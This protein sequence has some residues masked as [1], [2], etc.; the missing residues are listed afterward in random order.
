MKPLLT[1]SNH[2][3]IYIYFLLLLAFGV[4]TGKFLMS[5]AIIALTI[6]W[7]FEAGFQ[8]KQKQ[9]KHLKYAPIILSG[10]FI[11]QVFWL[12]KTEVLLDGL[13]D[14][15]VKLPLVFLPL[16]I[17]TSPHLSFLELKKVSFSFLLGLFI[18]SLIIFC[19]HIGIIETVKGSGT[20]RD[21]SIFMS[22]IRYSSLVAFGIIFLLYLTQTTKYKIH[23]IV[24]ILWFLFVLYILQS[25]SG[26]ISIL[27]S[28]F[29]LVIYKIYKEGLR[30]N[31]KTILTLIIPILALITYS[32]VIFVDY[33]KIK[34]QHSLSNLSLQSSLGEKYIH[35]KSRLET[36]NGH[37]LWINIAPIETEKAWNERSDK[38]FL[39]TKP[40]LYRYLTSKGYKKDREGVMALTTKDIKN[41]EKG[42]TSH[43]N[44]N[45]FEKRL[46]SVF[47]ELNNYKN[48]K[49]SNNHSITQRITFLQIAKQIISQNLFFGKGTGGTK[50]AYKKY[51]EQEKKGLSSK[52]QL[53]AHNQFITEFINLGLIGFLF[54]LV[55]IVYPILKSKQVIN[56]LYIP[57]IAIII[58]N[59]I[60]DDML[61]RQAGVTIFAA[62]NTFLLFGAKRNTIP[63][64]LD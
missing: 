62:V 55:S 3:K 34:D 39:I 6:N 36:E 43:I 13:N 17:G 24:L 29:I 47:F 35:D 25:V 60:A 23:C 30:K 56:I 18:S 40:V 16:I 63:H 48:I 51:Y 11:I 14:L 8:Q 2:R 20:F 45:L 50:Q 31:Y 49:N 54:W 15:R 9:N 28:V 37:L 64:D 46:R 59:F 61:E 1:I 19:A 10:V 26:I 7:L 53:R 42:K 12:F 52:N 22:H 57:F 5:I 27:V 44:Y 32:L 58:I 41:I 38:N 33:H 21:I 4:S